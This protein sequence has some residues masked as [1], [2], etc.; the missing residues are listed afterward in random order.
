[1]LAGLFRSN[2]PAI[3]FAIPVIVVALFASALGEAYQPTGNVMPLYGI[4]ERLVMTAPWVSGMVGMMLIMLLSIQL[5]GLAGD[6]EIMERRGHLPSLLFPI[7]LA[8][9]NNGP[10]LDPALAGMPFVIVALRNCWSINNTGPALRALFDA[11]LLLGIAALFHLPYAFLVVVLWA[12]ASVIRPFKWREYVVP[13]LAFALAFYLTGTVL[14]VIG[15]TPWRPLLTIV[16][17]ASMEPPAPPTQ[18]A[19]RVLLYLVIG[20]MLVVSLWSYAGSYQRGVMRQKNLRSSFMAF[21]AA[22]LV[23]V[24]LLRIIDRSSPPVLLAAP[25]AVFLAQAVQ[26]S[27]RQW[28][29]ESAIVALLVLGA[30]MQWGH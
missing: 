19:Q 26:G 17:F 14:H 3:L 13:V 5:T 21:Q 27:R 7:L 23:I 16:Q 2:Q 12:S 24:V 1:M 11:G 30:W 28:L 15:A 18:A 20:A 25:L 10:I 6:A 4:L 8:A 22:L 29:S 9:F